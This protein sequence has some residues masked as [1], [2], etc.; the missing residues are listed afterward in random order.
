LDKYEKPPLDA[1]T[2]L[3]SECNYGGRVTDDWD[4]R[5]IKSLLNNYYCENVVQV[6]NYKFCKLEEYYVFNNLSYDEFIDYIRQL[7][8]V[9]HPEI[10]GLHENA[11]ITRD[12]Q[13]TQQLFDGILL[14]LP[15]QN[16]N[17]GT[18]TQSMIEDLANDILNRL[19]PNFDLDE[20]QVSF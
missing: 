5:L 17:G 8:L 9:V 15:R 12:F 16:T 11:N 14:T 2:Y 10:F 3:T 6:D 18:S 1:L 13:E 4:R 20:V 19:P 7:P